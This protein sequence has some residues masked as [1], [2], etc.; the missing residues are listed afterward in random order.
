MGCC[1]ID[2]PEFMN[3]ELTVVNEQLRSFDGRK[4]ADFSKRSSSNIHFSKANTFFCDDTKIS[5][6]PSIET[7]NFD[8]QLNFEKQ[9]S[10]SKSERVQ[11]I[12]EKHTNKFFDLKKYDYLFSDIEFPSKGMRFTKFRSKTLPI[13]LS[14]SDLSTN[15]KYN[16]PFKSNGDFCDDVECN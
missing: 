4:S 15:N 6:F 11:E 5:N 13:K 16:R 12:K 2:N 1:H 14:D 9:N 3:T 8:D 10:L 7:H